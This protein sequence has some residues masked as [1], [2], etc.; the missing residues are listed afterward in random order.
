MI[1]L[2]IIDY[3]VSVLFIPFMIVSLYY[4]YKIGFFYDEEVIETEFNFI[5]LNEN[6]GKEKKDNEKML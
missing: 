2:S 4:L 6:E 5:T 3:L 1:T